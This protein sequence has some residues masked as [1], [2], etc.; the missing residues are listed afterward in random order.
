MSAAKPLHQHRG[1]VPPADTGTAGKPAASKA[2]A[3]KKALQR[4]ALSKDTGKPVHTAKQD[5]TP[6]ERKASPN[7]AS[8]P[9]PASATARPTSKLATLESLL[10]RPDGMTIADA[11]QATGWQAHS[12]RGA[13][14]GA[15]KKR[16]LCVVSQ[17]GD[18]IRTYRIQ[19]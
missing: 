12:V 2:V 3:Q 18:G 5:K 13:I 9:K 1:H 17:K 19:G 7:G 6:A 8:K 4:A 11:C 16:G 15:L 14:A 10:R